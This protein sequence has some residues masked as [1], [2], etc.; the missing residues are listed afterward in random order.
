MRA[1]GSALIVLALLIGSYLFTL[2]KQTRD[3]VAFCDVVGPGLPGDAI[4][5]IAANY[6]GKLMG[7]DRLL[8]TDKPQAFIYCAPITLCDVSCKVEVTKGVVTGREFSSL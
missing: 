2:Q 5:E 6:S 1:F 3:V 4:F 7:G 8:D